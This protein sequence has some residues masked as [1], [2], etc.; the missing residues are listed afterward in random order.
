MIP[1]I[2]T[3]S[4]KSISL[5]VAIGMVIWSIITV[6]LT[7]M[8]NSISSVYTIRSTGQLIPFI[9]GVAGFGKTMHELF[10]ASIKKVG[11]LSLLLLSGY[12]SPQL[13]ELP[14]LDRHR[15]FCQLGE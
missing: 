7:L 4:L 15:S 9:T 5:F 13:A 6:E 2:R 3:Q 10:I 11:Y 12:G 8:Y 1:I 14:R